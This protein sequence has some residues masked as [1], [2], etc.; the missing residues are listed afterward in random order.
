MLPDEQL[1]ILKMVESGKI[2]AA[3]AETLLKAMGM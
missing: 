3:Q 2:S 1:A